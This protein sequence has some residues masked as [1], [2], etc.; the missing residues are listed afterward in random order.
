MVY[1]F[2]MIGASVVGGVIGVFIGDVA[3]KVHQWTKSNR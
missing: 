3:F 1:F 2:A